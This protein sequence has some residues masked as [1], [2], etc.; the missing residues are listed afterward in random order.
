VN[1]KNFWSPNDPDV[2][3][4]GNFKGL[5]DFSRNSPNF[6]GASPSVVT[7]QLISAPDSWAHNPPNS[8]A[9][10]QSGSCNMTGVPSGS[11][12]SWGQ[13]DTNKD[14]QCSIQNWV[15]YGFRGTLKLDSIWNPLPS[16]WAGQE[17]P[18][19]LNARASICTAPPTPAPSCANPSMGDWVETASGQIAS[20][21]TI[22][23]N[24]VL[25]FGSSSMPYSD[26][27]VPGTTTKFGKGMVIIVFLWDCAESFKANNP[28]GNQWSLLGNASDCSTGISGS[29]DRVHLFTVAPFTVYQG[30][31]GGACPG[32]Q[33][34]TVCGYWGGLFG[35]PDACQSCGLSLTNTA[36]LVPDN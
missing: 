3:F 32:N 36:S 23:G 8:Y 29:V 10:D 16:G 35:N 9:P 33:G 24:A 19:T 13:A 4:G 2:A 6:F 1:L 31:I 14:K 15:Y 34:A 20:I 30:T 25:A 12:D 5:I 26:K 18:T 27:F 11:W 28:V 17:V 22:I 7:P 21:A